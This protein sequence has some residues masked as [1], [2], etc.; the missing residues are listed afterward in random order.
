MDIG[1]QLT[2]AAQR[3]SVICDAA[4]PVLEGKTIVAHATNPLNYAW[5]HH[6]QYLL[7]WGSR[8][9]HTL[10]LGMNPGPWR[11]DHGSWT[12]AHG[13]WNKS[14]LRPNDKSI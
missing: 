14:C 5:P 10:L 4:I 12:T 1:A 11:M 2:E 8:G 6:E 3:L 13:P 9:G 7:K